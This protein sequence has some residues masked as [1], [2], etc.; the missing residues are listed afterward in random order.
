MHNLQKRYVSWSAPEESESRFEIA[1]IFVA[2]AANK[3]IGA[4]IQNVSPPR[5]EERKRFGYPVGGLRIEAVAA[6]TVASCFITRS[7]RNA[8]FSFTAGCS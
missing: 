5:C 6:R 2:E 4:V 8:I 1:Q 3:S 7:S